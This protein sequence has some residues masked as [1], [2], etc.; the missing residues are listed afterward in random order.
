MLDVYRLLVL[1]TCQFGHIILT[2]TYGIMDHEEAR[3]RHTG[4]KVIGES[5]PSS[6]TSTTAHESRHALH[7]KPLADFQAMYFSRVMIRVRRE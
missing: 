2:T 3:R 4:G 6:T 5:Q 1:C 7:K